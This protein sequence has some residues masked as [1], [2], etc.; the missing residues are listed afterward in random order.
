MC[1]GNGDCGAGM[2]CLIYLVEGANQALA[3]DGGH[4]LPA[5][6]CE[7]TAN[8]LPGGAKCVL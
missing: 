5:A 8:N 2:G 3:D 7:D 4:C 1:S 6:T